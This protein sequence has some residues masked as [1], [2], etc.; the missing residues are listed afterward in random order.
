MA[1]VYR[2]CQHWRVPVFQRLAAIPGY[3]LK[4]FHSEG[5][6]GTKVVNGDN[7]GGFERTKLK[8]WSGA[9]KVSGRKVAWLFCPDLFQEL[10]CFSP[11]VVVIE[12][13]SNIFNNLLVFLYCKLAKRPYVWWTL[14]EIPG[15]KHWGLGKIYRKAVVFLEK[16]ATAL[17]GYSSVAIKYFRNQGYEDR[18]LFKAV[19]CVETDRVLVTAIEAR[20]RRSQT[21]AR[22][23]DRDV[24]VVLFVGA[25]TI[26]KKVDRLLKAFADLKRDAVDARLVLVGGG[27]DAV[28]L[29]TLAEE[30]NI[31]ESTF[32]TGPIVEG[33]AEYFQ[34]ADIYVLPGLGG[35]A[36]S[37]AMCHGLPVLCSRGDG[38][39]VDLVGNGVSGKI[40]DPQLSEEE[41]IKEY[42]AV[43]KQWLT[44][45]GER[46]RLGDGAFRT[47]RNKY[48]I[49]TYIQEIVRAIDFAATEAQRTFGSQ[50][51]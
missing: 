23:G 5:I 50:S 17:L 19:N 35:L 22:F 27:E 18:R 30:L 24:P 4:V 42:S 34:A 11:D 16:R 51:P 21:R 46:R 31:S 47:I 49:N 1:I 41:L 25:L 48:N 36:I 3:E 9:L 2:V 33:V 10:K 7:L 38:C 32:F 44:D 43:L 26:E 37:E 40:V 12:G 39:E 13:G 6:P 8:T 15:R 14:G 28:R 45:E 29:R 20:S